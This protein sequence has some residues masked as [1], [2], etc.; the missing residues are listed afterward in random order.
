L[1]SVANPDAAQADG[2]DIDYRV[3]LNAASK[4]V[5]SVAY[6]EAS[7]G[8]VAPESTFQFERLG[9]FTADQKDH[10]RE[11]PVFNRTVTLRD[12]FSV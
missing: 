4:E 9:Y 11:S 10:A 5:L 6:L 8:G 2:S 7:L 1:F 12:S 3:N